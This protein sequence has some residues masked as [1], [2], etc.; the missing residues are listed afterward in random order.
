[1]NCPF[2]GYDKIQPNFKYCPR[3]CKALKGEKIVKEEILN[4]YV[5]ETIE[6]KPIRDIRESFLFSHDELRGMIEPERDKIDDNAKLE[7]LRHRLDCEMGYI[8]PERDKID[9]NAKLEELHR[10]LEKLN[11]IDK[12]KQ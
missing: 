12:D 7:E 6:P 3:C 10:I 8:K 2:C 4:E 5:K 11:N 1:M 9:D